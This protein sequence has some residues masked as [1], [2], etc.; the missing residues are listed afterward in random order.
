MCDSG[1]V[2]IWELVF[3]FDQAAVDFP[4]REFLQMAQERLPFPDN[5]LQVDHGDPFRDIGIIRNVSDEIQP[6][7]LFQGTERLI[8][9][10]EGA[11]PGT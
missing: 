5:P 8:R 1:R 9:V 2:F 11:F 6:V 7:S 4:V 3:I 10:S